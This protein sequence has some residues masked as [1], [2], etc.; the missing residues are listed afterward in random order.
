MDK[1][2]DFED[3][4]YDFLSKNTNQELN[5]NKLNSNLEQ[6]NST[7]P[8]TFVSSYHIANFSK[9][10]VFNQNMNEKQTTYYNCKTCFCL[11]AI[12]GKFKID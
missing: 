9:D 4:F 3:K 7:Y 10:L 8:N 12:S 6:L 5:D 11:I 1:E 2:T